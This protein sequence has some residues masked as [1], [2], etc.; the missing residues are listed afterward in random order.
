MPGTCL[1]ARNGCEEDQHHPLATAPQLLIPRLIMTTTINPTVQ[2]AQL[3][4]TSTWPVPRAL[5]ADPRE[6]SCN[7]C[8]V[9]LL[10]TNEKTASP[11]CRKEK[12]RLLARAILFTIEQ[13]YRLARKRLAIIPRASGTWMCE[14]LFL[15]ATREN[16]APLWATK[17]AS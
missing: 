6:K 14:K 17:L 9:S 4:A 2:L 12:L 5:L 3:L 8:L 1:R 15:H 11:I 16:V 7:A 13:R 10:H